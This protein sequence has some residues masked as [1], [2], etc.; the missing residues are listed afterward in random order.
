M[1]KKWNELP[2]SIRWIFFLPVLALIHFIFGFIARGLMYSW[3]LSPFAFNLIFPAV[4]ELIGLFLVFQLVPKKKY[5]FVLIFIILR[6]LFIPIFVLKF[7]FLQDV[8]DTSFS[9]ND[10]WSPFLAE[11]LTLASSIWFYKYLKTEH[12]YE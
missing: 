8:V 5:L 9:W 12:D 6:S 1:F 2:E 7:I 3:D 10:Y 11:I 4:I